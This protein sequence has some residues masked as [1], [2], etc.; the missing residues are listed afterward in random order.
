MRHD[1]RVWGN[2]LEAGARGVG[3]RIRSKVTACQG[4]RRSVV[5]MLAFCSAMD[6]VCVLVFGTAEGFV[7]NDH[8]L[9]W[10][11]VVAVP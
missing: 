1:E 5:R 2:G 10:V 9:Q 11:G 7:P 3:R 6:D 8:C 4:W